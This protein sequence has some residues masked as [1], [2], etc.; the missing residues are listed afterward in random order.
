MTLIDAQCLIGETRYIPP[1]DD[2]AGFLVRCREVKEYLTRAPA[3][4]DGTSQGGP[5][6][7]VEPEPTMEVWVL[8][9][10]L[11]QVAPV[12]VASRCG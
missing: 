11:A 8:S 3:P 1:R 5:Y 10:M 4:C 9:G 6:R 7:S 12:V 2:R